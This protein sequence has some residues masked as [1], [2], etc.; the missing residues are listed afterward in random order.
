[1]SGLNYRFPT[2]TDVFPF[3]LIRFRYPD[4]SEF[5]PVSDFPVFDSVFEIKCESENGYRVFPTVPVRF[6]PYREGICHR[7]RTGPPRLAK[8]AGPAPPTGWR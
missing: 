2:D 8:L 1:M 5:V 4:I 7:P 3:G 6:Q